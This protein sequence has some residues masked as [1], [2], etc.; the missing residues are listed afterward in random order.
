MC[1]QVWDDATV[2]KD[3]DVSRLPCARTCFCP[4]RSTASLLKSP[5]FDV[6]HEE[7]LLFRE[8][9]VPEC[10]TGVAPAVVQVSVQ[11]QAEL[12]A[13]EGKH[14]VSVVAAAG[15]PTSSAFKHTFL[16]RRLTSPCLL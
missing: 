14:R 6:L 3:E 12:A 7:I 2:L 9:G 8:H 4:Q 16:R 5:D 10:L 1:S 15:G 13:G 11:P